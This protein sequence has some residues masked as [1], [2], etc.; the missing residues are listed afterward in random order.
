MDL[1]FAGVFTAP[2][3]LIGWI[4]FFFLLRKDRTGKVAFAVSFTIFILIIIFFMIWM[5]VDTGWFAGLG[6]FLIGCAVISIYSIIAFIVL[7][8]IRGNIKRNAGKK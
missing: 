5:S 8:V 2:A 4:I 1:I 7:S 3:T 6:P